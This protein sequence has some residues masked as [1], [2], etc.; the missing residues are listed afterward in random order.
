[1]DV[2]CSLEDLLS[3]VNPHN[4]RIWEEVSDADASRLLVSKAYRPGS[5][6]DRMCG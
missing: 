1:M 4:E 5:V 3:W 6:M 2:F